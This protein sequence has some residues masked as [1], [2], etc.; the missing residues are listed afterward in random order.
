MY[1]S[2]PFLTF[3]HVIVNL[4]HNVLLR[5]QVVIEPP[6][7]SVVNALALKLFGSDL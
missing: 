6:Q 2:S 3:R 4:F 7:P 1:N 5:D